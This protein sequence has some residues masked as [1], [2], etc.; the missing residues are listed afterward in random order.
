[1]VEREKN[2][3]L[4]PGSRDVTRAFHSLPLGAMSVREGSGAYSWEWCATGGGCAAARAIEA[5]AVPAVEM[6]WSL[7]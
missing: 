3:M 2:F 4:A 6:N 5:Q 1:M 7:P